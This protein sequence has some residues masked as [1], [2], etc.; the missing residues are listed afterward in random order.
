VRRARR[1]GLVVRDW[2]ARMTAERNEWSARRPAA[3]ARGEAIPGRSP[4]RAGFCHLLGALQRSARRC[5]LA[6]AGGIDRELAVE[7]LLEEV[8]AVALEPL[9][10]VGGCITVLLIRHYIV[11]SISALFFRR[12]SVLAPRLHGLEDQALDLGLLAAIKLQFV[13]CR[14][15]SCACFCRSRRLPLPSL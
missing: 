9:G 15:K 6:E 14:R 12:A 1:R 4:G 13:D 5:W 7:D 11:T 2:A 10:C 3:A 8:G